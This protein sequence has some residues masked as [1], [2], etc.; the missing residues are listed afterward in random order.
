MRV[1][2]ADGPA[3]LLAA[4]HMRKTHPHL[5]E[6][7]TPQP[8]TSAA[9]SA[10]PDDKDSQPPA[11]K[12]KTR[13]IPRSE[14]RAFYKTQTIPEL[15]ER[16]ETTINQ[17]KDVVMEYIYATYKPDSPLPSLMQLRMH[18]PIA[19]VAQDVDDV[20]QALKVARDAERV[21]NQPYVPPQPVPPPPKKEK[22]E[23]KVVKEKQSPAMVPDPK[24][25]GQM[26]KRGRGRPKK[27]AAKVSTQANGSDPNAG[28]EGAG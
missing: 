18:P 28:T 6:D 10:A 26:I 15:E 3:H 24:N 23:K 16:V 19:R 17:L 1:P 21:L 14:L 11:K 7:E 25:P 9:A 12:P 20:D 2:G 22:K 5:F 27:N 4:R 13:R 8:S